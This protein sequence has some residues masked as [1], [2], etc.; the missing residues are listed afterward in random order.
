MKNIR[1]LMTAEDALEIEGRFDEVIREHNE[2]EED[3]YDSF[4]DT[5]YR[6]IFDWDLDLPSDLFS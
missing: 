4:R 1:D 3:L 6:A 5:Q 2:Y